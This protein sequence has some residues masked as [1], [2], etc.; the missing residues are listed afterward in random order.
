MPKKKRGRQNSK[1]TLILIPQSTGK[2]RQIGIARSRMLT[3]GV[4]AIIA[5][6]VFCGVCIS[7]YVKR[8]QINQVDQIIS[9]NHEKQDTIDQLN[10]E[11]GDIQKQQE[12][13][14]KKQEEI[15]RL[16]GIKAE[17]STYNKQNSEGQ[18]GE[19]LVI[20][21]D[22]PDVLWIAQSIKS[23]LARQDQ[24]LDELMARVTNN[25][26]Y[27]RGV[28]NL[29]PTKG[30]ITSEYG[31]RKSPFGGKKLSFHNGVDIANASGTAILAAGDGK[32]IFAG[33]KAAYGR[34]I[35]IDHGT[36]FTSF[37]GHCS[38]FLVK[39]GQE[40]NKG[41]LIAKMGNSGNSTGPHLH[42]TV[43]KWGV[44]QDPMVYLP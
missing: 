5:I 22:D 11:M 31:W 21:T 44:Y 16:M 30:T 34:T 20:D 38:E 2:T 36:G 26:E 32:V 39:E 15:K 42:Y 6:M 40:V 29:M 33:W 23:E 41:Q 28:P 37:Y 1:Y 43:L 35:M 8:N 25:T 18:G 12:D 7:Y 10:Q 24:E 9:E 4:C 13:I 14:A 3:L 17:S 27:F 19:D